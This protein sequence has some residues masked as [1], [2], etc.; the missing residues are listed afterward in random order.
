MG[1]GQDN[2]ED[3]WGAQDEAGAPVA[4]RTLADLARLAGVS[5]GTVS[6]A[7]AGKSLVNV[8]TRERI[9]ALAREHGFRPNQMASKLR[10][11]RTGVIG[12]VIPL[13][14]EQRQ[15]ISDPFFLTLLG[16]LADELTESGY[17]V[18]L[19]RAI[20]DGTRDWLERM[21]GSGMVDGVLLIGQ[22]DQFEVIE[23]VARTYRPLVAWGASHE[24]QIHC[25]VG[26]DNLAGGRIAA[27][28]LIAAGARGLA[29]MGE[30][31]G[32]EIEERWRGASAAAAEAGVPIAH[33]PISLAS[34]DMGRQIAEAARSADESIDGIICA[35]D[36]IAMN[37]LHCLREKGRSVPRDVQ[38][39]G[40]DDLPLASLTVPPLTTIRQEIAKGAQIMVEK[41][42][43]RLEGSPAE[44]VKMTP[45]LVVRETTRA[46]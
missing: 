35:S 27:E 20:P 1:T 39:I 34:D 12:I 30:T 9:Q 25:A 44:S 5:T 17:D 14:H 15:H 11:K 13:G 33:I 2:S 28:H 26:T 10:S 3:T 38:V 36:L 41:L 18:M 43:A 8:E 24:G 46:T 42:K 31:K 19:S 4:V 16:W 21:T 32:I 45:L 22:S 6:R 29:F 37:V 23:A 40:F 7:L